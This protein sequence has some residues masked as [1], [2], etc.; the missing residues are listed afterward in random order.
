M[1][2]IYLTQGKVTIVDDDMFEEL[3][4]FKWSFLSSGYARRAVGQKS[5]LMHREIMKA[6]V[7]GYV[8]HINGNKLDNRKSNLRI[9]TMY[10]N[11]ANRGVNKN[12][13]S[14]YKGVSWDSQRNK[15]FAKV[16]H[17]GKQIALGRYENIKDAVSAYEKASSDIFGEF[18]RVR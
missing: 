4:K 5:I 11:G 8:D 16:E 13:K 3:S 18:A 10:E 2:K 6:T 17:A 9:C 15:W 1:K 14:G 7:G 12:N